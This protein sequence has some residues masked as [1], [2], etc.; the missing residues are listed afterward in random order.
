M[1]INPKKKKIHF[2]LVDLILIIIALTS[3]S[4]LIFVFSNKSIAKTSR[5][6]TVEIE[7]TIT[8]SPVREE[9]INLV[10]IGDKVI[11]T[12]NMDDCG[13][14]YLVSNS[15]YEHVGINAESGEKVTTKLDGMKSMVITIRAK[16]T[17]TAYGY[18]VN[19]YDIIIGEDI[20]VRVPDY[21][22]IGKCTSVTELGK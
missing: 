7:Y 5:S 19:G 15:D 1:N 9:Y 2:N 16:A 14:V 10:K 22:G 3:I 4:V 8:F 13:E 21:T 17:K 12:A 18:S 11:N 20:S 6:Q